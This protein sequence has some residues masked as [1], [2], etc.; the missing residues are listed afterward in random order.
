MLPLWE[1]EAA[2]WGSSTPR[3]GI[4]CI[5]SPVILAS[6]PTSWQLVEN[7]HNSRCGLRDFRLCT[8]VYL[9]F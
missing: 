3:T 7:H 4:G 6:S 2:N 9:L 5:T 1:V 8:I